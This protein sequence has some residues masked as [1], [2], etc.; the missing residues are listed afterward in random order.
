M[1][2]KVV[3]YR[4]HRGK[5]VM[6]NRPKRTGILTPNQVQAKSRF[7]GAVKYA[8][9]QMADPVSKQEYQ[10]SPDSRFTSAYSRAVAD[11]LTAPVISHVDVSR[12]QG[13]V[14]DKI[15]IKASDDFKVTSVHVSILKPDGT[16]LEQ[17]DAVLQDDSVDEYEYVAT[18]AFPKAAGTKV[19]VAVRDKPANVTTSE[20][21][22]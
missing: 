9:K 22:L 14:G 6:S 7:L 1:L 10:P 13:A 4:E 19:I 8:K 18:V 21:V 20:T 2:G 12:Y 5:L 17:G 16:L 15:L 11:F 3:V